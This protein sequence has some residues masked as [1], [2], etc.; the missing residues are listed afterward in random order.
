MVDMNDNILA[1]YKMQRLKEKEMEKKSAFFKNNQNNTV[2][3]TTF[4]IFTRKICVFTFPEE[5]S[6]VYKSDLK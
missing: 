4:K 3:Q 5:I 6:S 1:I 2:A